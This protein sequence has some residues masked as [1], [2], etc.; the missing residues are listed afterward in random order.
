MSRVAIV[1]SCISRDLWRFR[2]ET[3]G[4]APAELLYVSRT[5]LPSL[6]ATPVAGFRPAARP[7]EGLRPQPHRALVA[8]LRKTALAE[9]VAFRPT[10]L[11]FDFIDERFDLLSVAGSLVT[12][13]WELEASGY[14][15]RPAL[16]GARRI[17]RLSAACDRLWLEACSELAALVRAT[18]LAEARLILH[19]ARWAQQQRT[20]NGRPAP[21]AGV[22]ILPGRPADIEG[23]NA[24]L[25]RY[26][27]AFEALMPPLA[28]VAAPAERLADEAH[29]WG[30]S[31]FH[32][33]PAYYAE[34]WRQLEALGLRP[35]LAA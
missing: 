24:L 4:A 26:E 19:S 6:F 10:H 22:E 16:R 3:Q 18:P 2:G 27:E 28:R 31:P 17:A 29:L 34:V 11:I 33:V 32:Y 35:A 5:S 15:E 14:L 12:D 23:H 13:S 25:A 30:L 21:I 8:D 1:G 7:P 20:A 9:L